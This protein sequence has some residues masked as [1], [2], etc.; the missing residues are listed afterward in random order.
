MARVYVSIGSNINRYQHITAALDAL[1]KHFDAL[2]ISPVY[3][4][5][6]VGFDGSDF[7]NL[8]VGFQTAL[9]VAELATVLRRIEHDN[10]RRR[11]GPKFAPRTLDIDILT[12]DQYTGVI[13]GILLPRDEI[14]KNA[15][16]LLP[17]KDIAPDVLHPSLDKTYSQLWQE[18]NQH[19]QKLW[20]V[21]FNWR[22][23]NVSEPTQE[24]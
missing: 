19:S 8:V 2:I 4:S 6:S 11:R 3:E 5:K 13:D 17:L 20:L 22:G 1:D 10:G 24:R 14:T 23:C 21:D 15:F 7:L 18:Y 12:Y 9:S 16:V